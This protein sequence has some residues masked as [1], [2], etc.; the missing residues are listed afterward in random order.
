M[1]DIFGF[2][3]VRK[4]YRG[5]I[6]RLKPNQ[7]LVFGSNTEGRHGKGSALVA[8][9]RH[10]AIYGQSEGLQGNS[11][12]IITKDLTTRIHPSRTPEQ[13]IEQIDRLYSF[14]NDNRDKEFFIVYKADST[15]LNFYTPLD[16]AGFF[17]R[18]V[19]PI[20]IVFEEN[21]YKLIEDLV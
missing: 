14:A 3:E 7:I 15:N 1:N 17:K 20:N 4:T 13:I 10:G 8:R 5:N 2:N 21:F 12:A 16:M 18:E 6:T 19:I 11:Y 9:T